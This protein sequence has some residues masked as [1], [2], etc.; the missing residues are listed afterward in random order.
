MPKKDLSMP[1]AL[2]LTMASPRLQPDVPLYSI[3]SLHPLLMY[4]KAF[5]PSTSK[6]KGPYRIAYP[7][8]SIRAELRA[9]IAVLQFREWSGENDKRLVIATVSDY[10]VKGATQ[11]AR[12]WQRNGWKK[13]D[14]RPVKNP[15]LWELLIKEIRKHERQGLEILFRWIPRRLNKEADLPTKAAAALEE[16][17]EYM[18][19]MGTL[20]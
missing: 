9:V 10:T 18:R 16:V 11:C 12:I 1:M 8:T 7:Q 2:V 15:D 19:I 6:Q 5:C 13:S 4:P 17:P 3:Q 20:V 14:G